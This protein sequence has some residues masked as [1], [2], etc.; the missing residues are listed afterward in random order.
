M[1]NTAYHQANLIATQMKE[2]LRQVQEN[3]INELR[4]QEP[5]TI[6]PTFDETNESHQPS[7]TSVTHDLNSA[8]YT[9]AALID[10]IKTLTKQ[11]ADLKKIPCSNTI[12]GHTANVITKELTIVLRKVVTKMKR[13]LPIVWA[14]RSKVVV[15][16]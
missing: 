14:D 2:E 1:Q 6:E 5:P 12:V 8:T 13:L 11:V 15:Q 3:V 7:P 4:M 16:N 10:L 9:N